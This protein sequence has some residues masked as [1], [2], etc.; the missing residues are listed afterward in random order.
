MIVPISFFVN[1]HNWG[2]RYTNKRPALIEYIKGDAYY[3]YFGGK[4]KI[5]WSNKYIKL[6]EIIIGSKDD[7]IWEYQPDINS[8]ERITIKF[9]PDGIDGILFINEVFKY[10][11]PSPE[12]ISII[13]FPPELCD[14]VKIR[15]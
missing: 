9:E 11:P 4:M 10:I 1:I 15:V 8:N 6:N 13:K 7:S 5:L 2:T 14:T 3:K 12:N